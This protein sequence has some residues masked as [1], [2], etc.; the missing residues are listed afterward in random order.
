[1]PLKFARSSVATHL[2]A[3][4]VGAIIAWVAM[5]LW[6]Q[7]VMHFN[8]E[9]YG[10]L[11]Q[12]CDMAMQDHFAAKQEAQLH[13]S[14]EADGLVRAGELGRVPRGGVGTVDLR[15]DRVQVRRPVLAS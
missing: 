3:A 6:R 7:A 12:Q 13:P 8:Q 1:M 2:I 11:V 14:P 5:P 9:R 10:F 4:G 15:Q